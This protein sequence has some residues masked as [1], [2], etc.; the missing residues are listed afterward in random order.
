MKAIDQET[1]SFIELPKFVPYEF[2][3][4]ATGDLRL[5]GKSKEETMAEK[6]QMIAQQMIR[7]LSKPARNG[8]AL[9]L[10]LQVELTETYKDN[11][12]ICGYHLSILEVE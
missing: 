11:G 1:G 6:A 3:F 5:N 8:G 12:A 2:N 9:G 10:L 4:V 7:E